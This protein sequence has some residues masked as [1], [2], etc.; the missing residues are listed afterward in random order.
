MKKYF[1]K[2]KELRKNLIGFGGAFYIM[3]VLLL[4]YYSTSTSLIMATLVYGI[5][6]LRQDINERRLKNDI[7]G[8]N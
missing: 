4:F 2:N 3:G 8:G 6:M 1:I 5:L 7:W